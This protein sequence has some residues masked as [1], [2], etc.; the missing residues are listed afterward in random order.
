MDRL[1]TSTERETHQG[2]EVVVVHVDGYVDGSTVDEF[3]QELNRCVSDVLESGAVG[4]IVSLAGVTYINSSGLGTLVFADKALAQKKRFAITD[5]PQK[6]ARIVA[7]LGVEEHLP[8]Y[9][10]IGDA[11]EDITQG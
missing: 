10:A 5:V 4:L 3:S 7:L 9:D 11:L 1:K 6:I 8:V 2:S